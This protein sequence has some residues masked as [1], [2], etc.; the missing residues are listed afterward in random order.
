[1]KDVSYT[2]QNSVWD[3]VE[4]AVQVRVYRW[5]CGWSMENLYQVY[6][7]ARWRIQGV[8]YRQVRRQV[9]EQIIE[10]FKL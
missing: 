4:V 2:A 5:V 9:E 6:F 10:E 3:S 8:V 1:M 7:P